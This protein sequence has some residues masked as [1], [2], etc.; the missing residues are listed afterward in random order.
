MTI[1]Q[2]LS[3]WQKQ[4]ASKRGVEGYMIVPFGA[5]KAIADALPGT[6]EELLTVK[7]IGPAKV[8]KYGRVILEICAGASP[9]IDSASTVLIDESLAVETFLDD[10]TPAAQESSLGEID[11]AT[12]EILAHSSVT[13]VDDVYT[14]GRFLEQLNQILGSYFS[15]VR[16]RGE[17]IGFKRNQN[18]HAYFEIKDDVGIIRVSVFRGA[19]ELS[20]VELSDGVEVIVTGSPEHHAR[21]GFSFIGSFVELAGAGALKKAYDALKE[22]LQA[23]GL[24]DS[25]RKRSLPALPERVGLITSPTGAAI[26]DFTTNVGQYGY[27]IFFHGATVEGANAVRDI[28]R[29][30]A[31]LKEQDIDVLVITRGGGSLE[32]LQAFNNENVIRAIADFP[33][34]VVAGIGHEQDETLSTL[35]AD[36]GASTPTAAARAVR[37]GWDEIVSKIAYYEQVIVGGYEY[38]LGTHKRTVQN[39]GYV[40]VEAFGDLLSVFNSFFERFDRGVVDVDHAILLLRERIHYWEKFLQQN[41][42]EK[43]LKHGYSIVRDHSGAVIRCAQDVHTGDTICVQFADGKKNAVIE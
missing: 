16:V 12:G 8:R 25:D 43:N 7:G 27:H 18:G 9:A 15:Q 4:E 5:L 3:Q 33:V 36:H 13:A 29:A 39:A 2:R 38:V 19:Y 14:V 28:L 37:V 26:G 17:V 23:E 34:P 31:Y 41:H 10:S 22:K 42:P 11:V 21:Y 32:S 6:E 40:F 24:F 35:V 20:G 1:L 30:I